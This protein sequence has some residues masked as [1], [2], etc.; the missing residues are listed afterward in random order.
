MFVY[1]QAVFKKMHLYMTASTI[2]VNLDYRVI[3]GICKTFIYIKLSEWILE[4]SNG[5]FLFG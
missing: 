2:M 1:F 5:G 4:F 3:L